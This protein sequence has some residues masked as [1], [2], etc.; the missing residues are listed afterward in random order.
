LTVYSRAHYCS[1]T[2]HR[3][4]VKAN[5][6][7]TASENGIELWTERGPMLFIKKIIIG[8]DPELTALEYHYFVSW[9]RF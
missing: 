7:I 8:T 1:L 6:T 9:Q 5:G 2:H 3:T 4:F